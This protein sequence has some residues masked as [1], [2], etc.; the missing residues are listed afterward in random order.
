MTERKRSF[1]RPLIYLGAALL[2]ALIVAWIADRD[3]GEADAEIVRPQLSQLAL[4]GERAFNAYC[5][6]CHGQNAG[7]GESGPP[8]VHIIYEP[9]HHADMAFVRA[10][11]MGVRQHHWDFGNMPAVE[12]VTDN[13]LAGIIAYIRELQRANGID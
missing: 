7:G 8:L 3:G 10:V 11:R 5:A 1:R 12:G 2:L 4:A 6:G 9:S 13:D